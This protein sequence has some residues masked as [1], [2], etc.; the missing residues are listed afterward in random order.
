MID[1]IE[2]VGL[3]LFVPHT[4]IDHDLLAVGHIQRVAD[5]DLDSGIH[6]EIRVSVDGGELHQVQPFSVAS[7][8]GS[9]KAV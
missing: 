7:I 4:G 3:A 2:L 9:S 8:T 5:A 6:H 1:R